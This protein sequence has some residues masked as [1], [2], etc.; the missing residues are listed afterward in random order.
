MTRTVCGCCLKPGQ[1]PDP[2]DLKPPDPDCPF[3]D[4]TGELK[5]T[6]PDADRYNPE[7]F[8]QKYGEQ[9]R[10]LIEDALPWMKGKEVEWGITM[11]LEDYI[12]ELITSAKKGGMNEKSV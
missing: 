9:Y 7:P 11:D 2:N 6:V 5:R 10:R 8:I 1:F 4:G 3:C 12:R